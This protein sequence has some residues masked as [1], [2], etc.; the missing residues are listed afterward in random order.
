M[1]NIG[2]TVSLDEI[3]TSAVATAQY[4]QERFK[5]GSRAIILGENG[6]RTAML[7][8]G[9]TLV[10]DPYQAEVA[11]SALDRELT[12]ESLNRM[13]NA[14]QRGIPYIATNGGRFLSP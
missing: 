6:L 1:E 10:D 3:T 8:A 2:V 14:I 13:V 5:P 9:F 7:E 12:W 11:V 4:L